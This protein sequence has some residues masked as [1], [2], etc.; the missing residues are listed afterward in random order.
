MVLD[1][2]LSYCPEIAIEVC[3]SYQRQR[4]FSLLRRLGAD[5]DVLLEGEEIYAAA[6][7]Q[8]YEDSQQ[9]FRHG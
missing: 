6:V 2:A 8:E 3:I 5:L 7:C 9:S 4:L 1:E